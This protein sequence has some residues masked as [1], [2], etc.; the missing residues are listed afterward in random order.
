[1][2][3]IDIAV[4]TGQFVEETSFEEVGGKPPGE[5]ACPHGDAESLEHFL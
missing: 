3:W 1:M 5:Y 2:F 4:H